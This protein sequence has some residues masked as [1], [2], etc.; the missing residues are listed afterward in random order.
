LKLKTTKLFLLGIEL[1]LGISLF[2]LSGCTSIGKALN[3]YEDEFRCSKTAPFG[4]CANTP[5]V[6]SQVVP[7]YKPGNV[8]PTSVA[9]V[10]AS[11]PT[12][13]AGAPAGSTTSALTN[14][15]SAY[16]EASL[17]KMT[18]LLK[19]PVTPVVIPPVAMRIWIAPRRS[20]DD[21]LDMGQYVFVI[22]D[23]AHFALGDY[24]NSQPEE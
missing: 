3:P 9:P 1:F 16:R 5:E 8:A 15:E 19:D 13:T 6:Y 24:L 11:L 10:N 2:A 20:G 23:K 12:V 14:A 21:V 4:Q 18:K 7:G 17:N 22:V